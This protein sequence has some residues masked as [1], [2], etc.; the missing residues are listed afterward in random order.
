MAEVQ[1]AVAKEETAPETAGTIGEMILAEVRSLRKDVADL[2]EYV[3]QI[4]REAH[5]SMQ[6]LMSPDAMMDMAGKFLGGGR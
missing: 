5:E 1:E 6:G 4:E 2:H 3:R